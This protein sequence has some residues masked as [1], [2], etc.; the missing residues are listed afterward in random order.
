MEL[1]VWIIGTGL[2]LGGFLWGAFIGRATRSD[3]GELAKEKNLELQEQL[4]G[5]RSEL[6][7]YQN[8]VS[9][10]FRTTA[11]LV[12]EL[13]HSYRQVY[14]HLAAGSNRLCSGEVLLDVDEAPRLTA[15]VKG[16]GVDAANEAETRHEDNVVVADTREAGRVS[17][18]VH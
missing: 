1:W 3:D 4:N 15:S 18:S 14:E 9:E 17:G 2:L 6:A 7:G 8:E 11:T 12:Q 16:N 5:V 13:T 10:H